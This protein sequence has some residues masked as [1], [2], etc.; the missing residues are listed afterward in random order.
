MYINYGLT[1]KTMNIT[2]L[3]RPL[4]VTIGARLKKRIFFCRDNLCSL[5]SLVKITIKND[6]FL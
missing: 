2:S 3:V 1:K 6:S 5:G 4:A